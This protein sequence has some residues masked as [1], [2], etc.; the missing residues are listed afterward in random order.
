MITYPLMSSAMFSKTMSKDWFDRL[1]SALQFA[2][3]DGE[4]NAGDWLWK[5]AGVEWCSST[6]FI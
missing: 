1:M 3:N 6:S 4:D 2:D 5:L